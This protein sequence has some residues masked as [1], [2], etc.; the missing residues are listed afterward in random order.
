MHRSD[1]VNPRLSLVLAAFVGIAAVG[2]AAAITSQETG[3]EIARE[4]DARDLG[5]GDSRSTVQMIL[6]N[7]T[8][9]TSLR[10]LRIDAFE[11]DDPALG[12]MS[13]IVFDRPADVEGTAFLSHTK[14]AEPDNQWLYLPAIKRV[15]RISSANKSGPFLGSEFSNEDLLSFEVERYTYDWVRD[16]PC[17]ALRCFVVERVPVYA[18]S[19]YTRQVTWVDQDEYRIVQIDFYDRKSSLLKTLEF[20]DFWQYLG[21]YWR[22][23]T[24]QMDNHQTGKST[25]LTFGEIALGVGLNENIFTANRLKR[26]R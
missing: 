19:G 2:P 22:A 25:T 26:A 23:H 5:W 3:L 10:E 21:R 17:G 13:L 9:E 8:G 14:I 15:K 18:N 24:L 12:D 1:V 16:E 7:R 20:S 11:V 4:I 6:R